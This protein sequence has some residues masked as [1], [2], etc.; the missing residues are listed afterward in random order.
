MM[1]LIE[2]TTEKCNWS[3]EG[4]T[5]SDT[6]KITDYGALRNTDDAIAG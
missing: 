4:L 2:I 6:L 3:N 1:E 5:D